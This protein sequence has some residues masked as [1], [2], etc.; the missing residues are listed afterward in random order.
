MKLYLI[1]WMRENYPTTLEIW[2]EMAELIDLD[3]YL[4]EYCGWIDVEYQAYLEGED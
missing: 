4:E 2:E 1:E 3:I